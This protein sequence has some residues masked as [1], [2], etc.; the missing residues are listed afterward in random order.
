MNKIVPYLNVIL[1]DLS[2]FVIKLHNFHWN[3]IGAHFSPLHALFNDLYEL[4]GEN[5]DTIAERI[6]AL[7]DKPYASMAEFQKNSTLQEV[8]IDTKLTDVEMLKAALSDLEIII[9]KIKNV[10]LAAADVDD[11]ATNN[12]LMNMLEAYEKKAWMVRSHIQ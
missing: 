4:T 8:S 9:G 11:L 7:Q 5:I 3:V 12:M 1:S 6:R 2:I 10:A